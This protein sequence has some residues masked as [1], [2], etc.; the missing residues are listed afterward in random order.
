MLNEA[1]NLY[2]GGYA[3]IED[4]DK[5]MK[6]E[7]GMLWS[8]MGPFE[9]I[10]LN[11]PHGVTDYAARYGRTYRDIAREQA[12][13]DWDTGL[14]ARIHAER[15]AALPAAQMG[16]RSR[17]R[18]NGLMGWLHTNANRR[19]EARRLAPSRITGVFLYWQAVPGEGHAKA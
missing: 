9:T 16:Q 17:W 2:A 6:E 10:D 4:L 5:V 15:R 8:F 7:L 11:A 12:G 1:L 14:L 3:S 18:D 13:N 19:R